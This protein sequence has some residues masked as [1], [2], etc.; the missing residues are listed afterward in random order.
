MMG[1][2]KLL[3]FLELILITTLTGV[4]SDKL[5]I[6]TDAGAD[7]A[8]AI[9]LLLSVCANNNINIDIVAITCTYGNSNLRNVEKNVLKTL[10]IANETKIP[11]FSGAYKPLIQNHTYDN[12]FGNDGFGDFE[13]NQK[14]TSYIDRSKHAA[15]ALINL[16]NQYPGEL[17]ILVLGPTTNIALAISLDPNFVHK[18]KSF[19]V[20]GG[21]V[22][23]YGNRSPGV[24]FNFGSDPE[25][26]FIFFNSTQGKISLLPWETNLSINISMS[27]RINVL[28][29]IDSKFMKFL[30]QGESKIKKFPTWQPCDSLIVAIMLWPNL[31]TKS[32]VTNISP[33]MGGEAR[34]G[35]LIDYTE[36]TSKPKNVEIIQEVDVEEFQ[37]ILLLYLSYI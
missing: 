15:I 33:I 35:L 22:N 27:W 12:F 8:M 13:F 34:G 7:D 9:L 23:G 21:S 3:I 11:V 17:S 37:R 36:I 18:V 24:E 10:T 5:V 25:S 2:K 32:F 31:I 26:N 16:A 4:K 30:N 20:M 29:G 1:K 28:G 6:D 19:Y 14:I